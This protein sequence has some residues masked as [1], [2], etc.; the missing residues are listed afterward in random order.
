MVSPIKICVLHFKRR[1]A[2]QI[3]LDISSEAAPRSIHLQKRMWWTVNCAH[4]GTSRDN[5]LD[6]VTWKEWCEHGHDT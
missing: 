3:S 6:D 1:N 2:L 5:A 4:V